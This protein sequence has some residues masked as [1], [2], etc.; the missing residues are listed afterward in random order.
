[1]TALPWLVIIGAGV[2][3]SLQSTVVR[4]R[5]I[6]LGHRL[7]AISDAT[8]I[9]L[10]AAAMTFL[11]AL[12]AIDTWT[13][14]SSATDLTWLYRIAMPVAALSLL[15]GVIRPRL[16]GITRLFIPLAVVSTIRIVDFTQDWYLTPTEPEDLGISSR[17][18]TA[19]YG[20]G[21]IALFVLL[22]Y[23][24]ERLLTARWDD[25]DSGAHTC[26]NAPGCPQHVDVPR[27]PVINSHVG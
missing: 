18:L 12:R 4:F 8:A 16:I 19:S 1:V 17:W 10:V 2:T 9:R 6:K 14:P 7:V 5:P 25:P 11:T 27:L 22:T 3:G 23:V 26:W 21:M 24:F 13:M 15:R 20:W